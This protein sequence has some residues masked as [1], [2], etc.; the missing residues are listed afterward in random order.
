MRDETRELAGD[1][2]RLILQVERLCRRLPEGLKAA[3]S[4]LAD[5]LDPDR[6]LAWRQARGDI[7]PKSPSLQECVGGTP[8]PSDW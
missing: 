5:A 1:A 6:Q 7:P 4:R 2:H 8:P 3:A